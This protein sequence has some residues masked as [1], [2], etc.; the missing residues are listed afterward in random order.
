MNLY[1]ELNITVNFPPPTFCFWFPFGN[2][3]C[4]ILGNDTRLI[5]VRNS[6][7]WKKSLRP[8]PS[9]PLPS[10]SLVPPL[11]PLLKV[12]KK[13]R[14]KI[15]NVTFGKIRCQVFVGEYITPGS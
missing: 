9:P 7:K 4:G 3:S 2:P 13:K 10:W 6:L 5:N 12:K 15:E 14:N 8:L 1:L 11:E